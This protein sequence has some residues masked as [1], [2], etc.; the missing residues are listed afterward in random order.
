MD[1]SLNRRRAAVMA[2]LIVL[3][4]GAAAALKPALFSSTAS[5]HTLDEAVRKV[6][7][8]IEVAKYTNRA[9]ESWERYASWVNLKTGPTGKERYIS[10]GMYSLP[11]LEGMLMEARASASRPPRAKKLEALMSRY[12]D[13]YEKL[14]PVINRADSYYESKGYQTDD[15]AEGRKLH[16]QMVPLIKTFQTEREAMMEALRP[17][18][19]EVEE[20]EVKAME[21]SRRLPAWHAASVMLAAN[22]VIDTFPR[23]RPVP[24][25]AEAIDDAIKALGPNTPGAKFDEIISG[26]QRP[27]DI[28]IDMQ[29]FGA[30]LK[31]YAEA[32]DL[33]DRFA[34]EKPDDMKNFRNV[35]RQL[36]N[37]L[38][39]LEVPLTNSKGRD[40]ENSDPVVGRVVQT[41]FDMISRS[42][43]ISRSQVLTLL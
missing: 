38:R 23:K 7:V 4:A 9:Q 27:T 32:V 33:F 18:V 35:P 37:A 19:R 28:Q 43:D 26:V 21:K 14:A 25:S 6:N 36:L 42:S 24:I 20:L 34:A 39:A 2:G 41:Y 15:L 12:I 3:A 11:N 8:Y 29:R 10:Y 22:R 30:A 5:A 17:F 31:A 13:T 40:F 1:F 16:E